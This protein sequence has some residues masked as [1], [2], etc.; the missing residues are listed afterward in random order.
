MNIKSDDMRKIVLCKCPKCKI[1][2]DKNIFWSGTTLPYKYCEK[3]EPSS[4]ATKGF[5]LNTSGQRRKGIKS[6]ES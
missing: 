2:H 4:K 3:C 5:I 6:M 1:L